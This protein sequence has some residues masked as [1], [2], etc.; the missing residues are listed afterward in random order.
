MNPTT[1]QTNYLAFISYRHADNTEEDKQW[2]TWLHQQLEVYDIPADLIGS[3]NQRGEIIPE[4][5]YPVFRDEISLPADSNL[6]SAITTA[7]DN[8]NFLIVLCSPR[9]VQSQYVNDEIL[10]F[11]QIGKKDRIM[12]ALL[13]GEPNASIDDAKEEDPEDVRTLECFPKALQYH[14]KESGELDT[15]SRTEPIAANFRLPDGSKGLTNPNVYKQQLLKQGRNKKDATRLSDSYEEQLNNAKLKIIAGIL[16]VQLEQLTQRDKI[17]QLNKARAASKR[18]MRIAV[19]MTVLSIAAVVA[20]GFA[21]T[22]WQ[23]AEQAKQRAEQEKHRAEEGLTQIRKSLN[24]MNFDLRDVMDAHVPQHKRIKIVRQ[25]DAIVEVLQKHDNQGVNGQRLRAVALLQKSEQVLKNSKLNSKRALPLAQEGFELFK[26]LSQQAPDNMVFQQ[27]LSV[28]YGVLGNIQRRLGDTQSALTHYQA[29]LDIR[30]KLSQQ[31]PD[32]TGFQRELSVS[33]SQL[34]D[35]QGRLGGTLSALNH[36]QASF[37]ILKKLSQQYPDN[38]GYQ[39]DLAISY[40][41]LGDNK[42]GLKGGTQ[43]ALVHYQASFDI[44]KKLSQ[45]HPDN[46]EYQQDLSESYIKLGNIQGVLWNRQAALLHYQASFDIRK[47]L[48][49]QDP[50]N[51]ELQR[52]LSTSYEKLGNIQLRLGN[53]PNAL[54]HYQASL[55]ISKKLSQQDPDNMEY[56]QDLSA[57]YNYLGGIYR[58]L[59]DTQTALA[60]YQASLSIRKKLNQQAPDNMVFQ[61]KLLVSYKKLSNLQLHLGDIQSVLSH[62]QASVDIRKKISQQ[63]LG[64]T[65]YQ[66]NL[67][68]SYE[69]LGDIQLRLGY[70]QAAL[71]HYQSGLDICKKLSQKSPENS[72]N[73]MRLLM[74]YNKLGGIQLHLEDAGAAL[75]HYQASLDIFKKLSQQNLGDGGYYQLQLSLFSPYKKI[76]DIQLNLG[77]TQAALAHYQASLDIS[78]K[79]S[80][81]DP[82][83]TQY[84]KNLISNHDKIAITFSALKNYQQAIYHWQ[85]II[86]VAAEN[87]DKATNA[88]GSIGRYQLLSGDFKDAQ[89]SSLKAYTQKPTSLAW[90]INLAHSYWLHQKDEQRAK[91]QFLEVLPKIK[92]N[93]FFQQGPKADFNIFA[94]KGWCPQDG[95]CQKLEKWLDVA[96]QKE[97]KSR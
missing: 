30:K 82:A 3:T 87:S 42:Q 52:F 56:Q 70:T 72:K 25:I 85:Q 51:A 81:L 40:I 1:D 57:S 92:D 71:V 41:Q 7:L 36:Y 23:Q 80:Q 96:W 17:F 19:I 11:K 31:S 83:N 68:V 54:T 58:N 78:K 38:V 8:S 50:D 53:P 48:S 66:H 44:L 89:T 28:A 21:Y 5:I 69:N 33:Y 24:F 27:D 32:N 60:H 84:Q 15:T 88:L 86:E 26:K 94:E 91:A 74:Y 63:N 76:G 13:L 37:D 4:R 14:L 9:S 93:D 29:G 73:K 2:A 12:A 97:L 46:T 55:D 47:R 79:F 67:S 22:Q 43:L 45:Q 64:N 95:L 16:G 6:A 49:Q 20:T 62:Y 75:A 61:R 35:I 77:N 59:G 18:L 10:Y 34:G 90:G 65:D 39:R